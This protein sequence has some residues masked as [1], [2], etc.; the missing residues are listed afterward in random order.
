MRGWVRGLELYCKIFGAILVLISAVSFSREFNGGLDRRLTQ[1]RMLYSLFGSMKSEIGYMGST[2]PECFERLSVRS[3][4]PFNT[5]LMNMAEAMENERDKCFSNIWKEQLIYLKSN[6]C[7]SGDD[8]RIL[9]EIGDKLGGPDVDVAQNAIDY[10]LLQLEEHRSVI[11]GEIKDT[12]KVVV[13]LSLFLGF[14]TL[15]ILL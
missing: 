5:W 6:S 14:M 12:R 15:I 1:L 11:Q 9:E 4:P 8:I 2:L 10:L 3:E 13:S 7:L